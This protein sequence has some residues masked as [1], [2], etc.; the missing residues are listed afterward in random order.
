MRPVE[1]SSSP[2]HFGA[3]S[4]FTPNETVTRNTPTTKIPTSQTAAFKFSLISINT[5]T[6]TNTRNGEK[7]QQ[8]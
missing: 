7:E 3:K 4:G 8:R 5:N 1:G 6:N 2:P